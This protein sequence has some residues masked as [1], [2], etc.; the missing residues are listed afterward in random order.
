METKE[1]AKMPLV[2]DLDGTLIKTELPWE[3]FLSVLLKHPLKLIKIII[4]KIKIQTPAFFKIETKKW[5]DVCLEGLPFSPKFLT[6]LKEEKTLGRKLILCTGST[7]NY[8]D[9]IQKQTGLFDQAYGS[10]LGTNLVG[11]KKALFLAGKFGKGQF[12]YAGN[13]LADLKIAPYARHF[14]LVNPSFLAKLFS[15]KTSVSLCFREKDIDP[16]YLS[17]TL[18]FPLW[19][20]NCI[21]FVAPPLFASANVGP[22]F[23]SLA[24]SSVHFNFSALAFSVLFHLFSIE[25]ERKQKGNKSGNLFA[26]GDLSIPFGFFLFAL[27]F[28]LAFVSLLSLK[29]T[30]I[31]SS[32]L[33]VYCVYLLVHG[34]IK[35]WL[36]PIP[37]RYIFCAGPVLLQGFFIVLA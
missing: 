21:I 35:N 32:L 6:W 33:Y 30:A 20:L 22:L 8:A 16:S 10:T 5:A 11:I 23:L 19:F 25:K 12:D 24:I 29:I 14:I 36:V 27:F 2:V 1:K 15:K 4:R 31:L 34:K 37:I 28:T 9:E 18:A 17:N 26:T 13:A 7:Q 3:V